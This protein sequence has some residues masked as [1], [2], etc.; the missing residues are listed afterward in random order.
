MSQRSFTVQ[1]EQ[2]EEKNLVLHC[3]L[4]D[5]GALENSILED[6]ISVIGQLSN[7]SNGAL[8]GEIALGD[9]VYSV[10]IK[11]SMYENPLTDFEWGTLSKREVAAYELNK[12]LGW[13]IVPTTV[14]RDVENMESSV[15]VFIPHDPRE[16][17]FTFAKQVPQSMEIFCV[18]DYLLNNADRKAGHILNEKLES[19][20]Y[21]LS[22]HA[23][24]DEDIVFLK[25]ANSASLSS[26]FYGIDHGLSFN[27]EDKLRT[28]IWEFSEQEISQNLIVDVA[29]S[30]NKMEETLKP[31]LNSY[32]IEKTILRAEQL[33]MNP[34]HRAF[35]ANSRAFPWPLV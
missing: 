17:Y 14:L 26:N 24:A 1:D 6:E 23:E 28:V 22:P 3:D 34:Y 25:N 19:F 13:N 20:S 33:V 18:F 2:S 32:E 11:P 21:K 35:D 15:Q 27:V 29:N 9:D 16:H 5:S 10:V 8:L 4:V 30:I 7:S 31:Y 12:L